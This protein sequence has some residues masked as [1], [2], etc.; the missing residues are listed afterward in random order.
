MTRNTDDTNVVI[1]LVPMMIILALAAIVPAYVV[2]STAPPVG[3]EYFPYIRLAAAIVTAIVAVY[4]GAFIAQM[5]VSITRDLVD[6][7]HGETDE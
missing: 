5:S 1:L 6:A 2:W 4:I 3:G 7:I